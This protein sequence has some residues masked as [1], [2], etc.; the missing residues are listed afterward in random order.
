MKICS[1]CGILKP[2]NETKSI[3]ASEEMAKII[4]NRKI[5]I[6]KKLGLNIEKLFLKHSKWYEIIPYDIWSRPAVYYLFDINY[7][8][9]YI[10][11]SKTLRKRLTQHNNE[12]KK[13]EP[14]MNYVE[15][16]A[17]RYCDINLLREI[18]KIEIAKYEPIFN[19]THKPVNTF[20][21]LRCTK[22]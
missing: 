20:Q 2:P 14:W 21:A 8:F 15:Y 22:Q 16:I 12:R 17:Y 1:K 6:N 10:G 4:K 5:S 7:E 19:V 13:N 11:Q 9:L 18:E 3:I